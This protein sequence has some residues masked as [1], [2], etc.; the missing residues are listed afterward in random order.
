MLF[1]GPTLLAGIGQV[2]KRYADTFGGEYKEFGQPVSETVHE[3]GFAFVL[4]IEAQLAL[5]DRHLARCKTRFYM[6]VCE[7]ETVH[8][9][10][11]ILV[12]RYK[13][14]YVPSEFCKKVFER[15]FP[16]GE[17]KILRHAVATPEYTL[18]G[19]GDEPYVFYTIGNV[20]DP[21]KNIKML[22]EAFVRLEVPNVRLLIKATCRQPYN[23]K[24]PGV[25]VLNDLMT[26]EQLDA[27]H[28]VAHCYVNCSHAEGVGM[29]AV[30]AA[31]R[32]KPVILTEYGGLKEY[33]PASPFVV[34]CTRTTVGQDDF[35]Y[36]RDME[37]GQPSLDDLIKHMRH[38]ATNRLTY[39]DH[40]ATRSLIKESLD[41]FGVDT[42]L[43]PVVGA[44]QNESE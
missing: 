28:L 18:T 39:W 29:G 31:V 7:T 10:Y 22:L 41:G 32:D 4:P 23:L 9:V 21:R 44:V 3:T 16:H 30:E 42:A 26:D 25:A 27:I 19:E 13:T 20:A 34:S 8:P 2:T 5:V 33:V 15:Q 1:V 43:D 40:S 38:C 17:F 12:D 11:G 24:L 35:L 14:L 6:T 36:T 37:W